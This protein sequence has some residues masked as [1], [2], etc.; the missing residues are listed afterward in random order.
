MPE[1]YGFVSIA[2]TCPVG[3]TLCSLDIRWQC[4]C[5]AVSGTPMGA[6][7]SDGHKPV[8]SS[9]ERRSAGTW[10][11]TGSPCPTSGSKDGECSRFGN[12]HSGG[13]DV[14]LWITCYSVVRT[15]FST[16]LMSLKKSVARWVLA[17]DFFEFGRSGRVYTRQNAIDTEPQPIDARLPLSYFRARLLDSGVAQVT[18]VSAVT[19]DG[20]LELANRSSIWSR[21]ENGWRLRFHQ[22]TA[23]P[24]LSW[25]PSY[26]DSR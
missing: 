15:S 25:P 7:C 26:R 23:I 22:G 6:R 3:R 18:Y 20:V 1:A 10:S 14:Y 12:A 9:G 11:G 24:D 4:S 8:R 2:G 19:Y 16:M 17:P 21:T 13:R 5:M